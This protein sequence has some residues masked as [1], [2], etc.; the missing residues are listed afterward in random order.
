[1]SSQP[2][3]VGLTTPTTILVAFV[4]FRYL[5]PPRRLVGAIGV[6]ELPLSRL[7]VIG[8][9]EPASQ[10]QEEGTACL[11]PNTMTF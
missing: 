9:D 11:N 7:A 5:E 3:W 8:V 10:T 2:S 6:C 1:M 4:R